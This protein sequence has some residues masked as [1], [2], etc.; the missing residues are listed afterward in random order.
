M[1]EQAQDTAYVREELPSPRVDSELIAVPARLNRYGEFMQT[2]QM[3]A[4]HALADE[5]SYFLATNP[6]PGTALQ[7]ATTTAYSATAAVAIYMFNG[8]SVTSRKRIHLD[9]WKLILNNT[10]PTATTSLHLAVVAQNGTRTPSAGS[11]VSITPVNV[12]MGSSRTSG[13]TVQAFTG[14]SAVTVPAADTS[15]RLVGRG[16]I[17]TS[18]GV[19]GDVYKFNFGHDAHNA[20]EGSLTAVRATAAA[21]KVDDMPPVTLDPQQSLVF[22]LWWL[23]AATAGPYFEWE[24]GWWER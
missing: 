23:T 22:I 15:A 1:S 9:Y 10:A 21:R 8:N 18:L 13:A 6:T 14:G 3:P 12:N 5:G 16:S 11:P 2:N 17:P 20:G 19:T 24:L 4:R 7:Y